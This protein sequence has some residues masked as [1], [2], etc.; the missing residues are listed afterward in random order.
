MTTGFRRIGTPH[1][2]KHAPAAI[3]ALG[4]VPAYGR[5]TDSH[6]K[7]DVMDNSIYITVSGQAAMFQD[8]ETTANNIANA[9]TPGYN[10]QKLTFRDFLQSD[11]SA[12]DAYADA[13]TQYRDTSGGPITV[14]NNPFDLAISGP[15]YFQIDT[16][17]GKRFTKSGN[18]QING[19]G[20]MVNVM[21]Y[22]VLGTDGGQ[23]SIPEG[24]KNVEINSAGQISADGADVGQVGI[25]EFDNEQAMQRL[26]NSLYTTDEQP[27]P[28]VTAR[29]MQ[30]AIEGSNVSPVT[31]MVHVMAISRSVGNTAKFIDTMYT[32]E[33]ETAKAYTSTQS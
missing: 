14:T 33:Q 31:E 2:Q 27:K 21:G 23:I 4:M 13:P 25:M 20:T 12:K 7:G 24:S 15:G 17:L 8:M 5:G 22:P 30:G 18:F 32:L 28:A 10:A 29:V 6:A 9:S 3:F 1:A 16:P 11:G 19:D 26:G